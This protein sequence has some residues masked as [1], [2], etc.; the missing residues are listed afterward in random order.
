MD[1]HEANT[2]SASVRF[3]TIHPLAG[4]LYRLTMEHQVMA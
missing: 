1:S 3:V 2:E 4:H